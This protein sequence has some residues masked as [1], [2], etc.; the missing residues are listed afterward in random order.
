MRFLR[1]LLGLPAGQGGQSIVEAVM[2]VA[3]LG[4]AAQSAALVV[5]AMA[6]QNVTNRDRT[7][8][9]EKALQMLEELRELVLTGNANIK[10]L[11]AYSD[12]FNPNTGA[13][14]YRW[15]LTTKAAITMQAGLAVP[16]YQ[17]AMDPHSA[18]PVR[19]GGFAFVR[20][21]DVIPN[22]ADA[23]VRTIY[24]R[25]YAAAG[26]PGPVASSFTAQPSG[27]QPL[28]EVYGIVHSLGLT[29]PPSQVLD[30]YFVAL[31]N[32]P[33]WW[34][35]TSNLIPLMQASIVNLQAMNPGL[36]VRSHWIQTMS[37]GRDLE[38][39]PEINAEGTLAD[40][41]G[42]LGE[43]Y[44]YPGYVTWDTGPDYYYLPS[45]FLGRIDMGGYMPPPWG[46]TA[47]WPS[48]MSNP[49][50]GYSM[51]DQFNHAMRYPDEQ[52][53][54]SVIS[55]IAS[56]NGYPAPQISWRMLLEDLNDGDPTV[57]NAIILN[58][59]GEM[60]PVPPLR[61]YS[62]AARDP[63][64]YETVRV[65]A[66]AYRAVAQPEQ[67][68]YDQYIP[69]QANNQAV[70]VY[71]YDAQPSEIVNDTPTT[72]VVDTVT[73]YIPNVSGVPGTAAAPYIL[74]E[75]D[76]I[77]GNSK[78]PYYRFLNGA[79]GSCTPF[80]T[81]S[82]NTYTTVVTDSP[83]GTTYTATFWADNY[84]PPG[85]DNSGVRIQLFGTTPTA[86]TFNGSEY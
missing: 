85:R 21:V 17:T 26:N 28:A 67:L 75:I 82:P 22:T 35:R 66:R 13:V 39:T 63:D 16:D 48:D 24:V 3:V 18:N 78:T 50:L 71:A 32:V 38:Y 51:A 33:G 73:L 34:M 68:W 12:T 61:N 42:A 81:F 29:V 52:N 86:R 8:A 36:V 43:T 59:H 69:A 47:T 57:R 76:R 25:V 53:L 27:G 14:S 37:Y 23:N 56:N 44:V 41:T 72:E 70:N 10:T 2:A 31:E 49:N 77:Q 45:W 5:R 11:D 60:V 1:S 80:Y 6:K 54:Y 64:Y 4:I 7:L 58:L 55:Q 9:T 65:P 62:D 30:M 83:N 20:H 40:T 79:C 46:S 84:S 74:S 19:T 15:T